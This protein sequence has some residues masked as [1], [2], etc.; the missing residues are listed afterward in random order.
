MLTPGFLEGL[1]HQLRKGLVAEAFAD[2]AKAGARSL[3]TV[4]MGGEEL[5]ARNHK[6]QDI[7]GGKEIEYFHPRAGTGSK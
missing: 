7:F 6:R 1:E 5:N 4:A 3:G 2:V